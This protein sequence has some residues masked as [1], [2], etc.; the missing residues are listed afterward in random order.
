MK[1]FYKIHL[2]VNK[3]YGEFILISKDSLSISNKLTYTLVLYWALSLCCDIDIWKRKGKSCLKPRACTNAALF[4]YH[5][6]DL[7]WAAAAGH[8]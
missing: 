8:L 7:S 3:E 2:L 5:F 1:Q 6:P 4:K